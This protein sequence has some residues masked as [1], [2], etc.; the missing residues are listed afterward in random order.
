METAPDFEEL[1][2]WERIQSPSE[3]F[4]GESLVFLPKDHEDL[5]VKP[6]EDN[7]PEV[8]N[9]QSSSYGDE[10]RWR[11]KRLCLG[12]VLCCWTPWIRGGTRNNAVL[13][14]AFWSFALAT[15]GVAALVLVSLFRR[16]MLV[17]K[18]SFQLDKSKESLLALIKE[19]EKRIHQLLLQIAQMNE[20]LL[21]RRRVRVLRLNDL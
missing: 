3:G 8:T 12:S 17:W 18:R 5:H 1:T 13:R 20:V 4:V 11:R 6:P 21:A 19:K 16:R 9:S 7:N 10:G 14:V 2:D 15:G